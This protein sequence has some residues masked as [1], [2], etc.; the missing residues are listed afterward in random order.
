MNRRKNQIGFS[1]RVRLEWLEITANLVLAGNDKSAINEA[2]QEHLKDKVSVGGEAAR[3]NREKIISILMT[4]WLNVPH[5]IEALRVDGL[6]LLKHI[7]RPDRI[8]VH[9]GM[10]MVV[11]PF[12]A[13]VASYVGRFLKLQGSATAAH[14]QRRMR[15][16][17]GE[18][19]TVSRAA[20]RVLRSFIDWGV[21]SEKD[22]KGVYS[23]GLSLSIGD[24]QIAAWLIEASLYARSNGCAPLKDLVESTG[25]FPFRIK[26]LATESLLAGSPRL[27]LLR[28][29]LDDEMV[30]LRM[31]DKPR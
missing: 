15:E 27:D 18:R 24:P 2:L 25:L 1:Q 28:H 8:A 14:I 4:V 5:E 30:M 23:Q 21:L 17:Y 19:E 20:R 13:S 26:H 6:E 22:T 31:E 3:G 12:W 10:V 29:G 11:Y 9:W 7:P 16:Q